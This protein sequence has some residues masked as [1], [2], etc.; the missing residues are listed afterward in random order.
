MSHDRVLELKE[1][2][3]HRPH[4]QAHVDDVAA[5]RVTPKLVDAQDDLVHL[6]G[7]PAVRIEHVEEVEEVALVHVEIV[8]DLPDVLVPHQVTELFGADLQL[9]RGLRLACVV[10]IILDDGASY[11]YHDA[12]YQL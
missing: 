3:L 1:G 12:F 9:R 8:Q 11:F 5:P 7:P 2:A 4:H 6:Q 10:V